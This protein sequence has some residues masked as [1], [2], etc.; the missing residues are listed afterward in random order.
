LKSKADGKRKTGYI[1]SNRLKGVSDKMILD[2]KGIKDS[3]KECMKKL[4]NEGNEW[5]H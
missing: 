1:G 5:D 3:W 4:M 2:E